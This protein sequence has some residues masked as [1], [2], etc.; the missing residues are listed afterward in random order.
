MDGFLDPHRLS[1]A[2]SE[3]ERAR[4]NR[5]FTA[6]D[7]ELFDDI[8]ERLKALQNI[9]PQR[10]EQATFD[11]FE[12]IAQDKARIAALSETQLAALATFGVLDGTAQAVA[13]ALGVDQET[14][15]L[16][17]KELQGL[18]MVRNRT[19]GDWQLTGLGMTAQPRR[20]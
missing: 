17:L 1:L 10:V 15:A 14:A 19:G 7:Q 6:A 9:L 18:G 5:H 16:M 2:L 20:K 8:V 13:E 4:E 11:L 12:R 3:V